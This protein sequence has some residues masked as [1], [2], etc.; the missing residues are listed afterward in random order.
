MIGRSAV[1]CVATVFLLT[2]GVVVGAPDRA[3]AHATASTTNKSADNTPAAEPAST[4]ACKPPALRK[5]KFLLEVALSNRVTQLQI[6]TTRISDT[7]DISATEQPKLKEIISEELTG[8][9]SGGIKGLEQKVSRAGNCAQLIADAKTMVKDFWVYALAS[10]Q[11]DL[12]AVTSVESAVE[13]SIGR[14]RT[15]D[16]SLDQ[17]R[18]SNAESTRVRRRRSSAPFNRAWPHPS[19]RWAPCPFRLF[20]RSSR[21]T[22]QE[23]SP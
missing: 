9:A 23:I 20:C 21:P 3:S 2:T 8:Y 11:I 1:A 22:S 16:R 4:V 18:P 5:T 13:R 14:N 15:P 6:L 12:T 7:K 17:T 19:E 10:P